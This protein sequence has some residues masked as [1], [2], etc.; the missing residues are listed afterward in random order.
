MH[1]YVAKIPTLL[2]KTLE[3][4]G[5]LSSYLSPRNGLNWSDSLRKR[6]GFLHSSEALSGFGTRRSTSCKPVITKA[7]SGAGA[8]GLQE[9]SRW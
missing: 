3:F 1:F 2:Q 6:H 9:R 4:C 7:I 5:L 8:K